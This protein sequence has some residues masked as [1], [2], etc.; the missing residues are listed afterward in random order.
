MS[1]D[2]LDGNNENSIDSINRNSIIPIRRGWFR[3]VMSHLNSSSSRPCSRRSRTM[4]N[5]DSNMSVAGHDD[6]A[7]TT[8][9]SS[10]ERGVKKYDKQQCK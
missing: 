8:N 4:L 9:S 1:Y 3:R 5:S 2:I 10:K 7:K 6:P